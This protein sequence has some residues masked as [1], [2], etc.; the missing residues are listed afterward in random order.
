M[1]YF[2]ILAVLSVLAT[3]N[4]LLRRQ[5]AELVPDSLANSEEVAPCKTPSLELQRAWKQNGCDRTND[6][7]QDDG[8]APE[9]HSPACD[10]AMDN[11]VQAWAE[12]NCEEALNAAIT[13]LST[14]EDSLDSN[15][16]SSEI[17]H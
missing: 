15:I 5:E 13:N 2:T 8:T 1:K 12:N 9:S 10:E 7:G 14:A 11:F 16:P 17:I 6:E 3:S 4:P